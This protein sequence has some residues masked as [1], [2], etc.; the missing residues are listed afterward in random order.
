MRLA[1]SVSVTSIEE[2]IEG[3]LELLSSSFIFNLEIKSGQL[4]FDDANWP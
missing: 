3:L 4:Y 2:S 1:T